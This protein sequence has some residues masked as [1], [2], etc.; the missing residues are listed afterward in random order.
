MGTNQAPFTVLIKKVR[1]HQEDS[2]VGGGGSR[3]GTFDVCYQ[4]RNSIKGQVL[5]DFVSKFTPSP[6][7]SLSMCQVIVRS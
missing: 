2:E 1:F 5:A 4:P 3:L 7:A 6:R